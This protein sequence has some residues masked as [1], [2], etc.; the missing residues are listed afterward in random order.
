[1]VT[2]SKIY[3]SGNNNQEPLLMYSNS[4]VESFMHDIKQY[5]VYNNMSPAIPKQ[6]KKTNKKHINHDDVTQK[7]G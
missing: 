6:S 7:A 1:M 2:D 5:M 4:I 3:N